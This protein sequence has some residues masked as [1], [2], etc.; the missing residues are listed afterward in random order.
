MRMSA[1]TNVTWSLNLLNHCTTQIF[2]GH[3]I[4]NDDQYLINILQ[5]RVS[6]IEYASANCSII[7]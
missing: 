3:Q 2:E 1:L 5:P 6:L 4:F 7:I